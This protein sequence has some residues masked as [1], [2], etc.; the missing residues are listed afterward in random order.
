MPHRKFIASVSRFWAIQ[1]DMTVLARVT[2]DVFLILAG[3]FLLLDTPPSVQEAGITGAVSNIWATM[4]GGGATV[5]LAGVVF[6]RV[7]LEVYG[8]IFVGMGFAV[9]AATSLLK[10][11]LTYTNAALAMVFLSGTAGQ[12]YRVGMVLSGRVVGR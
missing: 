4:I 8:C 3:V 1:P 9:W 12:F 2:R 10:V 6:Y 11:D 7:K 5:A